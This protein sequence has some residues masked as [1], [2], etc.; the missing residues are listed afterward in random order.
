MYRK[1]NEREEKRRDLSH[2]LKS[3]GT[4]SIASTDTG[5][6]AVLYAEEVNPVS[7]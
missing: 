7:E 4:R 5:A 6:D 1:G 2:L 3:S